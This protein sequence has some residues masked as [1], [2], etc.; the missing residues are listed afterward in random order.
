MVELI[1]KKSLAENRILEHDEYKQQLS[2]LFKDIITQKNLTASLT[3]LQY[4][5]DDLKA[6]FQSMF[7]VTKK[8]RRKKG[9][10]I[11]WV[12]SAGIGLNF[13]TEKNNSGS[14]PTSQ[15]YKASF[16]PVLSF[17][18]IQPIDRQ[19]GK[20]FIYPKLKIFYY[21]NTNEENQ[22]TFIK[23]VTYQSAIVATAEISGGINLI[24]RDKF[25]FFFTGGVGPLLQIKGKNTEQLYSSTDHTPYGNAVIT[26]LPFLTYFI[27]TSSGITINRKI[28]ISASYMLPA[29]ISKFMYIDPK[30]SGMN[31]SIACKLR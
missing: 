14:N 17:G 1:Y 19:F 27:T 15:N 6:F 21:K 10:K 22:G 30:L 9:N 8:E 2:I 11:E 5:E 20:Y 25:R 29:P 16:S 7:Q 31:L 28:S 12:I 13:I 3:K 24:N 23:A 26:Q 4:R 18:F